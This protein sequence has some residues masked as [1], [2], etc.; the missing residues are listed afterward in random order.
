MKYQKTIKSEDKEINDQIR[1][2]GISKLAREVGLTP[3]YI[4]RLLNGDY[5]TTKEKYMQIKE[6]VST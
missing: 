3:S 4:H 2:Y 5:T 1:K 6:I